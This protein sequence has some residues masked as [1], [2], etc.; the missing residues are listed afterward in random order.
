MRREHHVDESQTIL[1]RW[2][3]NRITG[4][5]DR[6]AVLVV[7]RAA[8]GLCMLFEPLDHARY[9]GSALR[10]E[11]RIY[12]RRQGSETK[13]LLL[14]IKLSE[15]GHELFDWRHL[16]AILLLSRSVRVPIVNPMS[17]SHFRL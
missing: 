15:M 8:Q 2:R 5:V 6:H 13:P 16:Q 7:L 12:Q 17:F 4:I 14:I 9:R 11:I 10:V 3:Q 1:F